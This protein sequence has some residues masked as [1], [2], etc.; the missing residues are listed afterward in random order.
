MAAHFSNKSFD[1]VSQED[2][3]SFLDNAKRQNLSFII[4]Q[5]LF[6]VDAVDVKR[7]ETVNTWI[8]KRIPL[9]AVMFPGDFG[10]IR[11]RPAIYTYPEYL[12][13]IV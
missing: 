12:S 10:Q 5:I 1:N 7:L 9:L 6:Q 3:G 2:F 8:R 11:E 4:F 13:N